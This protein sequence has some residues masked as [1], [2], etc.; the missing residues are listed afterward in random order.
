MEKLYIAVLYIFF[1]LL[2]FIPQSS[3]AQDSP[4][5]PPAAQTPDVV[6][7]P[8]DFPDYIV[9][10]REDLNNF[11]LSTMSG[12]DDIDYRD[13]VGTL[14]TTEK[15]GSNLD[16]NAE[17]KRKRMEREKARQKAEEEEKEKEKEKNPGVQESSKALSSPP[18]GPS[19]NEGFTPGVK[20][21]L[22]MWKDEN[23]VLHATNNLGHVPIEY[24]M[25]ALENSEGS[26]EIK[27]GDNN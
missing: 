4:A 18:S 23:G 16:V 22:F 2:I 10:P 8:P 12:S 5:S 27:K 7:P 6:Q 14:G 21:G 15:R 24:Q 9:T 20:R 11:D 19:G 17:L 25:Q 26:L 1:G 13:G 3:E